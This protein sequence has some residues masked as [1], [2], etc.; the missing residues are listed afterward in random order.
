MILIID[1]SIGKDDKLSYTKLI[2][3]VLKKYNIDY[4]RVNKIINIDKI[5]CK[6][7]GIIITG[8]SLKLSEEKSISKFLFNLYYIN[9][10]KVPIYGICFG[11]QLL[12]L[13]YGGK[14]KDNKKYICKDYKFYNYNSDNKLMKDVKRTEKFSYCFSDKIKADKRVKVFSSIKVKDEIIETG[15]IF[16]KGIVYGTLF[17]PECHMETYKIYNNFNDI[18]NNYKRS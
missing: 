17:H 9:E 2:I 8:S 1:N 12:N 15:F 5:K 7:K 18:C 13:I 16:E 10:L 11:C 6:I 4:K 14:L 3:K